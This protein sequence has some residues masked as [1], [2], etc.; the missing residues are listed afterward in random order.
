LPA[1]Q[2]LTMKEESG[3]H[4]VTLNGIKPPNRSY[5]FDDGER[6][7]HVFCYYWEGRSS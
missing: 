6:P 3:L 2:W 7:L 4:L 5:R 1:G